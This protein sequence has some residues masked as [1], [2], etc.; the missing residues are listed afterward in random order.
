MSDVAL[1]RIASEDACRDR[2]SRPR[3]IV[4]WG[5]IATKWLNA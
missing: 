3:A 2:T 4:V 1:G 5:F